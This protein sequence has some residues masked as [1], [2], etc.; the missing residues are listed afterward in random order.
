MMKDKTSLYTVLIMAAL[1]GCLGMAEAQDIQSAPP[2][3]PLLITPE[4]HNQL[5]K[6]GTVSTG[7]GRSSSDEVVPEASRAVAGWNFIHATNCTLYWDGGSTYW[8][9][10]YPQEGGYWFTNLVPFQNVIAPACQ[11]GNWIAIYV[12]NLSGVL[13]NQVYTYNYK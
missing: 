7:A 13:W 5:T 6:D 12:Y 8:F 3:S 2:T 4:L 1:L 11:T 9:Y 10:I